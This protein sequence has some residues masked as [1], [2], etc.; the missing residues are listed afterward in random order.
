MT[1]TEVLEYFRKKADDYDRVDEQV[2]WRLSD[3]LLWEALQD[4]VL[5]RLPQGGRLLDAGGGTGRWTHRLLRERR[6][7]TCVLFDLSPDMTRHATA[8][9]EQDGYLD[10]LSVVNGDLMEVADRLGGERF[11]LV[12][13]F[14][15]V[16]GFV[17][18]PDEVLRQLVMLMAPGAQLALVLPNRYHAAFFNVHVGALDEAESALAEA[19]GRFTPDMPVMHLFTPA[20]LQQTLTALGL[21]VSVR[22]GFP[23]F[24]YPGY[25]ETQI[26]GTS[27]GVSRSLADPL[28]YERVLR[29]E[30][31][32]RVEPDLAERGNNLFFV[33]RREHV[34]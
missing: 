2:Y 22:S 26:E 31:R 15:N 3:Q 27:A 1:Q 23:A 21:A 8:K 30:R 13:S 18:D 33:A 20:L 11:D 19:R 34:E 25:Q 32:A 5:P 7:L 17:A 10:R 12:I 29:M 6:D 14:H 9:A 24:I 4:H 28:R 16:L